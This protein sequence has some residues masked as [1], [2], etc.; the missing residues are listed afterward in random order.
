MITFK[1]FA[2]QHCLAK[3]ICQLPAATG[4]CRGRFIRWYY[5]SKSKSCKD[6]VYGGCGGNRNNFKTEL[7]C[8]ETCS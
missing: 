4:H 2:Y 1:P 6:F 5:D 8:R 7:L 3:K